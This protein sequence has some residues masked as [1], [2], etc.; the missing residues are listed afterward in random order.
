M[1]MKDMIPLLQTLV[2]PIFWAAL[3]VLGRKP[4]LG[5]LAALKGRIEAGDTLKIPWFELTPSAKLPVGPSSMSKEKEEQGEA[6]KSEEENPGFYVV[7]KAR[8]DRSLDRGDYEYYR[9]RVYLEWDPGVDESQVEKVVY[10]FP[11]GFPYHDREVGDRA[12]QF[13]FRTAA[14]GQFNLTADVHFRDRERALHLDRYL[15]F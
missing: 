11:E 14:W 9:L 8:R 12:N 2:W 7:H 10:H 5:L 1:P 3:I 13:E 4:I 15:N 6:D